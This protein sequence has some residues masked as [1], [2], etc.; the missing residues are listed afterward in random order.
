MICFAGNDSGEGVTWWVVADHSRNSG[1]TGSGRDLS[2][3]DRK[4]KTELKLSNAVH[5][6]D[7]V[8]LIGGSMHP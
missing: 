3:V 5:K 1:C 4:D 7:W 6:P 2:W 8:R